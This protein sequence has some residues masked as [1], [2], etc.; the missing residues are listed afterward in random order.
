MASVDAR[1]AQ[2]TSM[3]SPLL[4]RGLHAS[5]AMKTASRSKP[6]KRQAEH[7]RQRNFRRSERQI[8]WHIH[9]VARTLQGRPRPD[10]YSTGPCHEGQGHGYVRLDWRGLH[11][12]QLDILTGI[13]QACAVITLT[14]P[15][16][17]CSRGGDGALPGGVD[18]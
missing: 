14:A 12:H 13:D 4:E 7:S 8:V 17:I 9:H 3:A 6:D 1:A 10:N 5:A 15:R 11:R 2:A 18:G 16:R